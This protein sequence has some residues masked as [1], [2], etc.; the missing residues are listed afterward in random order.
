MGQLEEF[1]MRY[2]VNKLAKLSGVSPRTLRF[3]DEIDLLK[4]AFYG[5]N[6]YRYYEEEQLL[7]L[8][9]ILF[10]RELGFPLS[11]IQ[12]IIECDDFNKIESLNTHKSLLQSSLEKTEKL[13]KTIDKTI[14]HLRGKVIMRDAEMFDG[15]DPKKQ[16]EH[17]KYMLDTGI[18]TQQQ[19]DESWQKAAHWKKQNWEQFKDDGEQINQELAHAMKNHVQPDA[20]EV[21]T[22]IQRH[23]S[24]VNHF[25]TPTKE[26]YAGLA[27][28]YLD[29]PDFHTFYNRPLA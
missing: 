15:F 21:Q 17:E 16:Q 28:M 26:S 4:P 10:F 7:V 5:D 14:S 11:D 25:W 27:Q 12:R 24:W 19:I 22:L 2:T 9:Q 29:H 3:Y 18:L 13:I 8:Q 23:Y 1:K 20:E 6:Q